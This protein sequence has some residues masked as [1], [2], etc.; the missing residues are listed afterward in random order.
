MT[1]TA[2]P[3]GCTRTRDVCGEWRETPCRKHNPTNE[4]CYHC[5]E[6]I[7]PDAPDTVLTGRFRDEYAHAECVRKAK[8]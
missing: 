4:Y 5:A 1:V 6:I 8:P 7:D 2:L 3:C